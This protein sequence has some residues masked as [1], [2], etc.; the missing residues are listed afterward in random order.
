MISVEVAPAHTMTWP[1]NATSSSPEHDIMAVTIRGYAFLWHQVRN[2]MAVLFLVGHGLESPQIVSDLLDLSKYPRKPQYN[3]APDSPLVLFDCG[4]DGVEFRA[5]CSMYNRLVREMQSQ[6]EESAVEMAM[7]H[8][9]MHTLEQD[10]VWVTHSDGNRGDKDRWGLL[11]ESARNPKSAKPKTKT[12]PQLQ[13]QPEPHSASAPSGPSTHTGASSVPG[14]GV[15]PGVD[16]N[17]VGAPGAAA[18]TCVDGDGNA[19]ASGDV[20]GSRPRCGLFAPWLDTRNYLELKITGDC[21]GSTVSVG[22]A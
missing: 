10:T 19:P 11:P 2:M 15:G 16:A 5:E 6:W 22:T 8:V 14:A 7:R 3:M 20:S 13:P 9:M 4:Y 17:V 21:A 12:Q 1:G 18:T